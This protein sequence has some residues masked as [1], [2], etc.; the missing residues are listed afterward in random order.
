MH[1]T[2]ILLLCLFATGLTLHGQ[3]P[4]PKVGY[5]RFWNMLPPQNGDFELCK[6]GAPESEGN[7]L[8]GTAYRYSSYAEFPSTRYRLVV[9]KKGD[10][11]T[12]L[13]T[14]DVDLRPNTF[15]TVLVSPQGG[16]INVELLNDTLDPKAESGTLTVRNYFPGLTVAVL[17][18]TRK[19]VDALPYGNTNSV[20]GFP[21]SRV[22]LTLQTRLPNGTPAESG[23]EADFRASK[24]ATLLIIP[25]SYG[26]FRPRV[27]ID[28]KNL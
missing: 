19:V 24:R 15:F 18:E 27:A 23:T 9:F 25:D 7:L 20:N 16:A 8:S 28:G 10:R 5:L 11:T 22:P 2:R 26:R 4:A 14:F 13:K 6:A 1:Q 3:T 17:S 12:P 21:L